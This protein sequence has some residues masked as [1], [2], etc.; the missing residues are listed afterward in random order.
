[1]NLQNAPEKGTLY[2]TFIQEMVYKKYESLEEVKPY[3]EKEGLLE[4]H[5][6][7][8]EKE[9]RFVKSRGKGLNRYEI[10]DSNEYDDV[11][12]EV[13][14]VASENVDKQEHLSEKIGVVNYIKY[15]ENDMLRIKNYRLKEVE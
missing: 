15:D 14:Y 8:K 6:F 4:L 11:Y 10:I 5:L 7:D 13:L 3:L 2:A 12:E 9:L 1:M